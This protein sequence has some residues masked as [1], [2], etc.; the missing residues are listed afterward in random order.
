MDPI[1]GFEM[2]DGMT[3]NL[4]VLIVIFLSVGIFSAGGEPTDLRTLTE[5]CRSAATNFQP[6]ESD[7]PYKVL[8][9]VEYGGWCGDSEN[10]DLLHPIRMSIRFAGHKKEGEYWLPSDP[11]KRYFIS[12]T[13]DAAGNCEMKETLQNGNVN[14]MFRGMMKD[15]VIKGV[16]E[17]GDGKKAF[18]F[19]VK[20][21]DGVWR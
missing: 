8:H 11:D 20:P 14:Y 15:G 18:A 5:Q 21:I 19:Y 1:E 4:S 10:F 7:F 17:K 13:A 9:T 12:A 2:A 16:W 6:V 3:R